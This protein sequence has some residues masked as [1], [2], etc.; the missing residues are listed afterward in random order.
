MEEKTGKIFESLNKIMSEVGAIGKN[1]KTSGPGYNYNFRGIDD[2]YNRLHGL[3]S[4]HGVFVSNEI[5]D[6][7]LNRETITKKGVTFEQNHVIIKM[8]YRFY[9]LDGSY[10]ESEA[11]GESIDY[12]DKAFAQA[13]SMAY[14]YV[15]F[16]IFCIP[17]NE[18]LDNENRNNEKPD[19][20]NKQAP[21]AGSAS[22]PPKQNGETERVRQ[23]N[24]A[25]DVRAELKRIESEGTVADLDSYAATIPE[26]LVDG[27]SPWIQ[28]I[29]QRL[30]E[31]EAA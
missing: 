27:F 23:S 17:T 8:R 10:V 14:K 13:Q 7:Q 20:I 26:R 4:E 24:E 11:P 1:Q 15:L 5:I 31:K 16:Q 3:F 21:K 18:Q 25:Q 19:P 22:K 2:I 30:F 28:G 9:A 12:N 6:A 29:R